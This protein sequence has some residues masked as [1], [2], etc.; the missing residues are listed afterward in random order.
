MR[1]KFSPSLNL[2]FYEGGLRQFTEAGWE[3]SDLVDVTEAQFI[4]FQADRSN[5]GKVRLV[6][7]EGMP[8]W[9]DLPAPSHDEL[10]ALAEI[11]R[12]SLVD[13]ANAI[14][15]Q[16]QWP[17]RLQLGRIT[18]EEKAKFV[19]ILDYLDALSAVETSQAPDINWPELPQD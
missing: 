3:L 17:S 9:A 16:N 4:E 14:I 12:Q 1:Y 6:N 15:G 7:S 8:Y 10:V 11:Q 19:R 5:E 2:F 18:D 13:V